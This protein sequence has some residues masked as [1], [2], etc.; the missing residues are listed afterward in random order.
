MKQDPM[1]YLGLDFLF[2]TKIRQFTR[3]MNSQVGRRLMSHAI[4]AACQTKDLSSLMELVKYIQDDYIL[5]HISPYD[6]KFLVLEQEFAIIMT[7][8]QYN[9][10]VRMPISKI[11]RAKTMKKVVTKLW[12]INSVYSTK[13]PDFIEK[14]LKVSDFVKALIE[15]RRFKQISMTELQ[16]ILIKLLIEMQCYIDFE[17]IFSLMLKYKMLDILF[18][19]AESMELT[20]ENR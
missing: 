8:C 11:K 18:E 3:Q 1:R 14:Y 5:V 17:E 10:Q 13:M 2:K 4:Q 15:S 7:L 12:T 6:V 20:D 16:T 19:F 9:V